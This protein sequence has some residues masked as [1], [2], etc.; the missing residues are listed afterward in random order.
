MYYLVLHVLLFTRQNLERTFFSVLGARRI[1]G[2]ESNPPMYFLS[3]I[4]FINIISSLFCVKHTNTKA[5]FFNDNGTY[6]PCQ[7]NKIK[8]REFFPFYFPFT[9]KCSKQ[10]PEVETKINQPSK[11]NKEKS[12]NK[13]H[14]GTFYPFTNKIKH[15]IV[16]H[17]THSI[18][19]P[20]KPNI[21]FTYFFSF[22]TTKFEEYKRKICPPIKF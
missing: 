14:N 9:P 7:I 1:L 13:L 2:W 18:I 20:T 12:Q 15:F 6:H 21:Y 4:F 10:I 17:L 22:Q 19:W 8:R 16:G 5:I 3:A 11:L